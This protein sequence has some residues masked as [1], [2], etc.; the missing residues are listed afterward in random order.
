MPM[1]G[2]APHAVRTHL[3]RGAGVDDG[4]CTARRFP[5]PLVEHDVAATVQIGDL[6]DLGVT[7]EHVVGVVVPDQRAWA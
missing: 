6:L 4:V 2:P 3:G 5:M 1:D 7:S